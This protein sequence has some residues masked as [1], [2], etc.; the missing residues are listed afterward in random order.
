MAKKIILSAIICLLCTTAFA[1]R[2]H[3]HLVPTRGVFDMWDWRFEYDSRVREVLFDGLS[4]RPIVRFLTLPSFHPERVVE[5]IGEPDNFF[6]GGDRRFFIVY[7]ISEQQIW[8]NQDLANVKVQ[9]YRTEIDIESVKLIRSLFGVATSQVRFPE[10]II[11]EES[12][13]MIISIGLDGTDYYFI[14]DCQSG[15]RSGTVWSPPER[16]KMRRLVDI[17][18]RLIDLAKSEQEKVRFDDEF[19]KEIQQLIDDLTLSSTN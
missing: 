4:N 16:S 14:Y 9:R 17:G 7:H 8:M 1:Q 12:G 6:I 2:N 13:M 15:R 5:I 3:D 19:Q 10:T 11:C 18:N